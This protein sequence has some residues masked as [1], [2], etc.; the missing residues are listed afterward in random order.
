MKKIII[1]YHLII[2]ITCFI[3]NSI[4]IYEETADLKFLFISE[5]LLAIAIFYSYKAAL[6]FKHYKGNL[7]LLVFNIL[8]VLSIGVFGFVYKVS[9]GPQ[10]FFNTYNESDWYVDLDFSYYSRILYINITPPDGFFFVGINLIQLLFAVYFFKELKN[11]YGFVF[12]KTFTQ[13]K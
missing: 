2:A 8:Q 13:E 4:A 10:I 7:F 6:D 11:E 12:P 9:Y 1:I 5:V 3:F